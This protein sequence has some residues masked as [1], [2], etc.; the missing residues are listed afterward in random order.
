MAPPNIRYLIG[1][2]YYMKMVYR[3]H[4]NSVSV[5]NH[6][7]DSILRDHVPDSLEFLAYITTTLTKLYYVPVY[8]TN[9]SRPG[10]L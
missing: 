6:F 8:H 2:L 7:P 3:R 4:S 9:T 5:D 10:F 1:L